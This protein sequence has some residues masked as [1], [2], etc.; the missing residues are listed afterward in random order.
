MKDVVLILCVGLE[1]M[2]VTLIVK[3]KAHYSIQI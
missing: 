3:F 1:Y 2:C